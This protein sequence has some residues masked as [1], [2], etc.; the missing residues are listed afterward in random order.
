MDQFEDFY[1]YINKIDRWG[2]RSGIVKIIPPKEWSSRLPNL[3]QESLRTDGHG[4][5]LKQARIKSPISQVI[6]GSRGLFRVMNVTKRKNFNAL[7]SPFPPPTSF[8]QIQ[9]AHQ[10]VCSSICLGLQ[11]G[12]ILP[13]VLIIGHLTSPRRSHQLL[14]HLK[15]TPTP[16]SDLHAPHVAAAGI[17]LKSLPSCQSILP[18]ENANRRRD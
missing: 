5:M 18:T 14:L 3:G 16:H 12:T 1:S 4:Q 9:H 6:Q 13:T 11:S 7:G 8:D 10:F 2:M 15:T 17:P